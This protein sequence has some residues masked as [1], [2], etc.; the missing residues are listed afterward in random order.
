MATTLHYILIGSGDTSPTAAQIVAGVSYTGATV[1]AAGDVTY[2]SAGTYDF[3]ADPASG[4]SAGTT[5]ELWAVAYDGSNYGTPV[6]G[7]VTTG[8]IF[9]IA[10][11]ATVSL[12]A[13]LS[14]SGDLTITE[15][16]T[17]DLSV[18]TLALA[19]ALSASGDLAYELPINLTADPISIAGTLSASGDLSISTAIKLDVSASALSVAGS[20]SASGDITITPAIVLDLDASPIS[21]GGAVDVTGDLEFGEGFDLAADP[22]IVGGSL[23]VSGDLAYSTEQQTTGRIV[24]RRRTK[25]PKPPEAPEV[26][27]T[28]E[29][30]KPV[31]PSSVLDGM[32]LVVEQANKA[33]KKARVTS[34]RRRLQIDQ[35]DERAIEKA[36]L[37]WF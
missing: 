24:R 19:G 12:S 3:D 32:Q 15:A 25:F 13:A 20:L 1:Y 11:S 2:T 4:L 7:S 9:D 29:E 21:I 22:I 35:E 8:S 18:S 28:P 27:E 5:Y 30:P 16:T 31:A 34:A 14:A 37:E 23:A 17:L 36:L 6:S 33:I 26:V 10:G